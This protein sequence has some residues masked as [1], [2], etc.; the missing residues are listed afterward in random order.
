MI[1]ISAVNMVFHVIST[2]TFAQDFPN[3]IVSIL[4]DNGKYLCRITEY[5]VDTI[6]AA[7]SVPDKYCEF[8]IIRLEGTEG[9]GLFAFQADN[10]KYLSTEVH[11]I[12]KE[13]N[14]GSKVYH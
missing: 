4:A 11:T 2:I 6:Q 12:R 14:R 7:K 10:G 5:G 1:P 9:S 13:P 8:K 3:R